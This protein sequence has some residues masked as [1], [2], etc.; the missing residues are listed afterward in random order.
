MS[1][2]HRVLV[3]IISMGNIDDIRECVASLR[4]SSTSDFDILLVENT[5]ASVLTGRNIDVETIVAGGNVGF[6]K[7]NNLG[8]RASVDR[9][10]F[11]TFLLNDDMVVSP[12]TLKSLANTLRS[13]T[14]IGLIGPVTMFYRKPERVW[15]AG[16]YIFPWRVRIGGRATIPRKIQTV[17]YLPG[18]GVMF[19]NSL[20]DL[21]GLLPTKYFFAYEEAEYCV[22]AKRSAYRSVVHPAAVA[23]HKVGITGKSG[24]ALTYNDYRNRL[25]FS[26]FLHGRYFGRFLGRMLVYRQLLR[27]D[28]FSRRIAT[29]AWHDHLT[30]DEI[31]LE[32]LKEVETTFVTKEAPT[33]TLS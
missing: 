26:E 1:N 7:G 30:F 20:V 8:I 18:S 16:G 29:K 24:P 14:D 27:T 31:K 11:A 23:Y 3:V 6:A 10:Y 12:D 13:S 32:H 9:G 33:I 28:L 5:K 21:I 25:I 15:A 4:A 22:R 2:S 17:D 19:R